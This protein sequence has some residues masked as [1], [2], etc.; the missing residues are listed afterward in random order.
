M[1]GEK[2]MKKI[3]S[4]LLCVVMLFS[5]MSLVGCAKEE[6]VKLGLGTV[7]YLEKVTNADADTNGSASTAVTVAGVLLDKDGKIVDC[8]IDSAAYTQEFTSKGKFTEAKDLRT[9]YEKGK[10]Y[11][12]VAYGGAKKEW[13]EQ[14]DAFVSVAKGKNLE[15]IKA[16]VA[17]DGKGSTDVV[18]AGCTVF[19]TD[20]VKA[21]EKAINNAKDSSATAKDKIKLGIVSAQTGCKDATEEAAGVNEVDATYSVAAVNGEGKVTAIATDS[22]QAKVSFSLKGEA[23]V[24]TGTEIQTKLEQGDNYGMVAYGKAAKEWYQQVAEFDKACIGKDANEI[25]KLVTKDG[26]GTEEIQTAGCTIAITDIVAAAQKAA[27]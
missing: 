12:M 21:L 2:I 3:L 22:L 23:A 19:V 15:E 17:T 9:K 18:T 4:V 7:A 10:D 8:V 25:A 5:V 6:N 11:G 24:A 27:K 13:F 14:V 1:K 16:L 26:K 20:F